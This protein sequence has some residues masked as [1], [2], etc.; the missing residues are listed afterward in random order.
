MRRE[1][2]PGSARIRAAVLSLLVIGIVAWC[3]PA[4]LAAGKGE[5][6]RL[7]AT[8]VELQ[9]TQADLELFRALDLDV[10]GL[11][12]GWARVYLLDE[13]AET[14]R[15]LGYEVSVLWQEPVQKP[16]ASAEPLPWTGEGFSSIPASYHT[17]ASLTSELQAIAA[18]NPSL[19][20]LVSIGQSV[21]GRELWMVKITDNPDVE[22]DEPEVSFIAAMH[23]DEVVGKELLVGLT[24]YL[25][26][27]YGTDM[28]VTDLVDDYEIWLMPS[29]NPDGTELGQRYNAGGFDLNRSFP[30]WFEDAVN[31]PD[32]RPLETG[33]MMAWTAAQS[34]TL[35]ANMHGG[36]LL[37]QYPWDNNPTHSSVFSPTADPAQDAFYSVSLTYASNNPPMYNGSFPN[38]VTNG[39]EWYAISGGMQDWNY[40]WYGNFQ[41]TLELSNSKWPSANQLPTFWNENL[42]SMLAFLERGGEGLR[43]LVTDAAT[44]SP[45]AAEIYLDADPFPVYTDPD[46]GDYHRVVLPGTYSMRVEAEGYMPQTIPVSIS[47]GAAARYDVQMGPVVTDLQPIS[48]RI[49]DGMFFKYHLTPGDTVDLAVTL[50]NEGGTATSVSGRLIPT[51]CDGEILRADATYPDIPNQGS[52]SSRAPSYEIHVDPSVPLGRKV[53]FAVGWSADQGAAVSE[54]FFLDVGAPVCQDSAATDVPKAILDNQLVTSEL[55]IPDNFTVETIEVTVDISHTYIGDLSVKL[56]SPAGTPV[57]LHN[58]TDGGAND[59]VGTYGV[60]LQPAD[61]LSIFAGEQA[62]GTWT[63]AINDYG[64]GDTGTLNSWSLEICAPPPAGLPEMRLREVRSEQSGVRLH[65]WPYPALD[66]YKVYRATD[67]SSPAQFVDVTGEDNDDTDTSFLDT[68]PL[69]LAYYLITGVGPQGEGP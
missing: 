10:D 62:Q 8:R 20:R 34:I 56:Y 29:M 19:V 11:F 5:P 17:Y 28:R 21:Q 65:W 35:S 52:A 43:G 26:D 1:H 67:P 49:I 64:N 69:P 57:T 50:K 9:D 68:T 7:S 2:S 42:E 18:A 47:S 30:D 23:G 37:A 15:S 55:P 16:V 36:A 51:G 48:V 45:V 25:V 54:P 66:S 3:A 13:E 61:S 12:D 44:G 59:I 33:L 24:N 58:R 6:G 53:G 27:G 63:L 22:E 4:A 40:A 41:L 46:V 14:L 31:T 38:G 39:A 60:D 32:G